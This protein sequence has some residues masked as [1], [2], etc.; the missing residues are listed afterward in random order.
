MKRWLPK[1]NSPGYYVLLAAFAMLVL[2]P[3]G[4]VVGAFM[5]FSLGFSVGGQVLAG[6]LGS[7]VT[8][9]YGP[10]GKHGANYM[11]TAAASVASV[12]SLAVLLQARAWLGLGEIPS[13]TL[14]LYVCA[15]A[16]FG[17]GVGMLY[18]PLVVDRMKLTFPSGFAVAN[19]LRALTDKNLLKAS[20][21]K[22]GTGTGL[23]FLMG[24]ASSKLASL[25]SLGLSMS[26]I[27]AGMVV[28]ARIA[29]PG[30]L[31]AV[32]GG[33]LVPWL[34]SIG[35]L[36]KGDPFR[37]IGF[38]IALGMILGAAAID[39]TLI[40]F[41]AVRQFRTTERAAEEEAPDWKR[42]NTWGLVLWVLVWGG[43]VFFVG[44]HMLGLPLV[45]LALAMGLVFVF[46]LIN[47]I[48]TGISDSNPVSAAFVI[49]VFLMATL[50]LKD[51]NAGLMCAAVLLVAC[52]VGVDMQ[53]DRSTGWRL[54]T[55]R[56]IQ[57]RYQMLGILTGAVLC[58]ILAKLFLNA[59]PV[60]Q[61]NQFGLKEKTPEM[62]KWSS[63]FT[64]KLVGV[65]KGL[66]N[67]NPH[68]TTALL[69]GITI[70]AMTNV[71]RK[72][73]GI[74]KRYQAFIAGGKAG[75]G[76]GFM[77]DVFVL[78]SPYASSFGGFVE[79]MTALWFAM[80]GIL[81]S[82]AQTMQDEA[83]G[84]KI[85]GEAGSEEM[86]TISLVGGGLIAGESLS[87]LVLGIY[88]LLHTLL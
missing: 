79:L 39:I 40:L 16:M 70:G 68:F 66:K 12:G 8:Y 23:G 33:E 36:E 29:V 55:N 77:V 41:K 67:P 52:S 18:T 24:L 15:I 6:I 26:T 75:F 88:A 31:M 32:V 78:P 63:A 46:L 80:G 4:A 65:L 87:A 50:G 5:L 74:W 10:E 83:R 47:G 60:L 13:L 62:A 56:V 58:V 71:L 45:P 59:Y 44:L 3:L 53:Q 38:V 30:L 17:I 82:F 19:I 49:G 22:L 9:G 35:W 2:G 21:S 11:Q 48:S 20:I 43:A 76:T 7:A 34:T 81:S 25:E 84:T 14:M 28:G 61:T 27:G 51:I 54:G 1:M 64:Y 37:K 86:S 73:L 57:F 69:I 85:E 42:T 72:L